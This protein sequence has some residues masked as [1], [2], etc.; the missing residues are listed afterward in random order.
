M[1]TIEKVAESEIKVKKSLFISR[2]YPVKTQK[3]SK[4]II[5]EISNKYSDATHNC[6]AYIVIDGQGYDDDGEPSG[7]AGKPIINA[8]KKN[9][10][11]NIVAIVTRYFG[12]IKLGSGGLTR[13]YSK[14]VLEAIANSQIIEIEYYDV[15]EVIF[16]YSD[17]KKVEQY[18]RNNQIH[19][20]NKEYSEK[21]YYNV[22]FKNHQNIEK[23]KEK[24]NIKINFKEK[25][26]LKKI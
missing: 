25:K 7:T 11:H 14:S 18:L 5:N 12:G 13:A 16:N 26:V 3:E 6:S 17:V 9:D 23:I 4:K 1:K 20:I 19:I 22:I 15:Y 24:L 2:L 8:L 10:L 21:I